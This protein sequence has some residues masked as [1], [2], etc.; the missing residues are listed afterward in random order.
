MTRVEARLCGAGDVDAG[1]ASESLHQELLVQLGTA[2]GAATSMP[3]GQASPRGA[4]RA[5][6][7]QWGRSGDSG[8]D[9]P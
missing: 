2:C 1:L 9:P 5:P 3:C 7:A 6:Q 4:L 8:Q